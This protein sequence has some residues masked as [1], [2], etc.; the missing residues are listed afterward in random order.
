M[1]LFVD[2][3]FG[4]H[5]ADLLLKISNVVKRNINGGDVILKLFALTFHCNFPCF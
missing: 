3:N 5:H 1:F 2:T 4:K